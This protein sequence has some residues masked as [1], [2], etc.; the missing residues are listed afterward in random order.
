MIDF[1][2]VVIKKKVFSSCHDRGKNKN[3]IL[4][5]REE[6]NLRPSEHQNA[7]GK[8]LTLSTGFNSLQVQTVHNMFFNT[9]G[10]DKCFLM[11]WGHLRL[12]LEKNYVR[13]TFF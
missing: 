9:V 6:S 10:K 11:F 7:K 1:E 8:R 3:K 12:N 2:L 4:S 13:T 5:I